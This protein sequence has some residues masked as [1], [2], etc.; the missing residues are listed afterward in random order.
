MA[1][2]T[3]LE[4]GPLSSARFRAVIG[5]CVFVMVGFGLIVPATPL[6]ATQFGVQ[7]AGAG[8]VVT[9]FAVTRLIGD[10]FAGGLIDR[11]GERTITALGVGIVGLSSLAAGASQN[12]AQLVILRGLGGVGSAFFLGGLMAYLIGTVPD[13]SRGRAMGVFQ[14]SVGI[15]LLIG[16]PL[17]GLLIGVTD[18]VNLPLYIYGAVCLATMPLALRAMG[19]ERIPSAALER[20]PQIEE[21]VPAPSVRAWSKIR[22]LLRNRT[23]IA[24]IAVT[25][26][27]F[28]VTSAEQTVIPLFW[29]DELGRSKGS[30]GLPFMVTALLALVVIW[31]AGAL[32]DKRGRKSALIPALAVLAIAT[33]A[34]GFTVSWVVVLV[35]M[36]VHGAASGYIR[37]GPSA[38]VAD[39]ATEDTRSVAV[40]G[41]R[42]AG[43]VGALVGPILAGVLA[44]YVSL[45]VA[46]VVLGAVCVVVLALAVRADETAPSQR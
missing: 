39:I 6:L 46:F 8:L 16:P 17:G 24:A 11:L 32:S 29:T 26:L 43:D 7:E 21:N 13:D 2:I 28:L 22:P 38:M 36:A 20:A 12:F 14:A 1:R 37:P 33:A 3:A 15:G 18:R 34:L 25:G 30:T 35:L 44:E 40:S 42:I 5:M 19:G 9:A 45:R 4:Q 10:L 27:G 41:Y 23:Y 31:H